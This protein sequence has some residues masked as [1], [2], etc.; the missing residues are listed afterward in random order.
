[1]KRLLPLLLLLLPLFAPPVQAQTIINGEATATLTWT[2]PSLNED[3]TPLAIADIAGYVIYWDT[4]TGVGRCSTYPATRLDPC[5]ANALDT[6]DGSA[7][8]QV[9]TLNLNAD[10][11]VYFAAVTYVMQDGAPVLSRYSNETTRE[12][13]LVLQGPPN[14]PVIQSVDFTITCITDNPQVTCTFIVQ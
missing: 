6:A 12:F 2:P 10:T 11:T 7:S 9:M 3:G 13:T 14:P 5:Y 1:M 4:Q 8:S